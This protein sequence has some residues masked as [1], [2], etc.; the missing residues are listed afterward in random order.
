MLQKQVFATAHGFDLHREVKHTQ[1]RKD[2]RSDKISATFMM[3]RPGFLSP[4][5]VGDFGVYTKVPH[6][7]DTRI[8]IRSRCIIGLIVAIAEDEAGA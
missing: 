8:F 1:A 6:K 2:V 3:L 5:I 7:L 4:T